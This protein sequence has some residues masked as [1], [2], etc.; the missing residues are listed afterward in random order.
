MKGTVPRTR[1]SHTTSS[2]GRATSNVSSSSRNTPSW[3]NHLRWNIASTLRAQPA[4]G[5]S[6]SSWRPE[7][8]KSATA[9]M[10]SPRG[11]TRREALASASGLLGIMQSEYDMVTRSTVPSSGRREKTLSSVTSCSTTRT[12]SCR[13]ISAMRRWATSRRDLETSTMTISL[14]YARS[15][16]TGRYSRLRAVPPPTS[17]HV[18]FPP[19]FRGT[20]SMSSERAW[21]RCSR[22]WS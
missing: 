14:K 12:K 9:M 6:E 16:G 11:L 7:A 3:A 17:T 5:G 1:L 13:F 19:F 8:W 10:P 22:N 15:T 18:M 20:D 21:R 4:M 2:A